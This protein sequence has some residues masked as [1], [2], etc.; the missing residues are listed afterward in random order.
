VIQYGADGYLPEAVCNYL[1]RLGW[2]HGDDELFSREQ[3]VSWFDAEH[4]SKGP[5]R[6]DFDKLKWVNNQYMQRLSG[7]ELASRL[8]PF[9]STA[10]LPQ[11]F[12]LALACDVL[13]DRC[14]T[15]L[16]L[17]DWVGRCTQAPTITPELAAS[18]LTPPVIEQLQHLA[19]VLATTE[20]QKEAI[21]T[22]IKAVL[23][24]LNIKMPQL[25]MPARVA[26]FGTP[27]TPGLDTML[28]LLPK[29]A[30]LARLTQIKG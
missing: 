22:T 14:S 23:A 29:S 18:H 21:A 9:L 15:L 1:A 10:T 5:A 2:S 20:W 17:R 8:K 16:D 6:F 3:F 25:A 13:K 26:L 19:T 27:Q 30:A 11:D 28:A 4:I 12:N 24:Q 7:A